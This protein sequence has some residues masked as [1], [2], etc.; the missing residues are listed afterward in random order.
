MAEEL[1][2]ILNELKVIR[3][4]LIKIG[5][6]RRV[7]HIIETKRLEANEVLEKYNTCIEIY[8][9]KLKLGKISRSEIH[10]VNKV[11]EEFNCLFSEILNLCSGITEE[12]KSSSE[13]AKM[14]SEHFDLKNAFTI[15]PRMT[16]EVNSVLEL[17]EGIE[18][19]SSV[20]DSPDCHKK[21]IQCVLKNRLSA[22]AKLKLSEKY[23][24]VNELVQDMKKRL[25]PQ[26]NPTALQTKLL[27][28]KQNHRSISDFGKEISQLFVELTISQANG[29]SSKHDVLKPLNEKFAIQRFSEGLRN[30]RLSTVIEAR[31]YDSLS[32]AIQAAEDSETSSQSTSEGVMGMYKKPFSYNSFRRPQRGLYVKHRGFRGFSTKARQHQTYAPHQQT[33]VPYANN[34]YRRNNFR[35]NGSRN[36]AGRSRTRFA[37]SNV[38]FMA[39][40]R[41]VASE[42]DGPQ[43]ESLSQFF[44]E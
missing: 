36:H 39:T 24:T 31:N 43:K 5:S 26:K 18:Y 13:S 41:D 11:C 35:S 34:N 19:Y 21:L 7:G 3:T 4:Y 44:R 37:R 23:D 12:G 6:K 10:L 40:D 25:I 32:D 16:D 15:L 29:D 17:I 1:T 38:N 27:Q 42:S 8:K 28:C 22:R 30:S 9:T 33:Q 2:L 20:L 14:S